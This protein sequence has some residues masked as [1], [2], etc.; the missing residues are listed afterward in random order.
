MTFPDLIL[1][2]CG[3]ANETGILLKTLGQTPHGSAA[4]AQ[5]VDRDAREYHHRSVF[6]GVMLRMAPQS[7]AREMG[8]DLDL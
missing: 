7:W 4:P 6:P 5:N 8:S 3:D 2:D 1:K